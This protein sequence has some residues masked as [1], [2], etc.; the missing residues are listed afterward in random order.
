MISLKIFKICFEYCLKNIF[1]SLF[2]ECPNNK[3]NKD[4]DVTVYPYLTDLPNFISLE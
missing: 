3:K 2:F 4:Q 1:L